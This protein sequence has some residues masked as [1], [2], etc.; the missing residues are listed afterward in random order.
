MIIL[1]VL[2]GL[3]MVIIENNVCTTSVWHYYRNLIPQADIKI[4][5][6]K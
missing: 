5:E 2:C 6:K 3:Q 4:E 1:P